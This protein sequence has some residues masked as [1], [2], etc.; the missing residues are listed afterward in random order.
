MRENL[1]VLSSDTALER[2][3]K[4]MKVLD[5]LVNITK[6]T[7]SD[8]MIFL[9]LLNPPLRPSPKAKKMVGITYELSKHHDQH[10]KR[11]G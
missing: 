5:G 1:F 7:G 11:N 10:P 4:A 9:S 2:E 8:V 3:K 6:E